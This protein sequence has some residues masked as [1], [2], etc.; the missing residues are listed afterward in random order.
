MLVLYSNSIVFR[1]TKIHRWGAR[2]IIVPPTPDSTPYSHWRQSGLNLFALCNRTK[3]RSLRSPVKRFRRNW[4]RINL[5]SVVRLGGDASEAARD[6]QT[7]TTNPATAVTST[8]PAPTAEWSMIG[9]VPQLSL[10]STGTIGP[11][12]ASTGAGHASVRKPKHK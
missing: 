7:V 6:Y 3:I 2:L 9:R 12:N 8:H 1:H 10:P 11:R 5:R 4:R